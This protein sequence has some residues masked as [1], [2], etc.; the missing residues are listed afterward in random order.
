MGK[1]EDANEDSLAS[2]L[3][4]ALPRAEPYFTKHAST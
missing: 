2:S 1:V 4:F 3:N